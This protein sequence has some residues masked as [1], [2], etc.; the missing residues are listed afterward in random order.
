MV[1]AL[2]SMAWLSSER[3]SAQPREAPSAAS[4]ARTL[5]QEALGELRAGHFPEARD[6][7]LRARELAPNAAIAFNLAV[8]Y[9]G[10]GELLRAEG[11]LTE[12][13]ADGTRLAA[14]QRA[15][16]STFLDEVR[17][18][19]GSIRVEVTGAMDAELRLDGERIET[20]ELRVDPGDHLVL[21]MATDR[22]TV[23]RRVHVAAGEHLEVSMTL[24]PTAESLV[25][26][27]VLEA[28][29]PSLIVE[30]VGGERG[31]GRL[32]A[33]VAPGEHV[34]RVSS[35]DQRSE[36]HV[37]VRAR[38]ETRY[39]FADPRGRSLVEEPALWIVVGVLVVGAGVGVGVGLALP[40]PRSA[41]ISDPVFGVVMALDGP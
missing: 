23:E 22:V 41:P 29:D 14:A 28:P 31:V 32:V 21:A 39:T 27:L 17:R 25:G 12:L 11:V 33:R 1:L 16:A 3:A 8:A 2:L 18:E 30:I 4:T 5:F 40:P 19:I 35:G 38:S 37:T 15:E 34:V 7:L 10:T 26:T 13:L 20:G 6:R 9:R 24:E 36:A